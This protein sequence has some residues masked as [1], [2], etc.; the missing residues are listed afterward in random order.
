MT[1]KFPTR[2]LASIEVPDTPLITKAIA[3]ARENSDDF[4]FN[5]VMRSWLFGERVAAAN[6]ALKDRDQEVHAISAI[7]QDLGW[8][9]NQQLISKDKRFEVDGANAAR[10]FLIQ[11]GEKSKWD[12]HRLQLVWDTIALHAIPSIWMYKEIEAQAA[13]TGI[14]V[15]FQGPEKSP[16]GVL[17]RIEWDSVNK[18]FPLLNFREA[19]KNI[20]CGFCLTKPDT[21]YDSFPREFGE[22]F[23]PGYKP[24]TFIETVWQ[25]AEDN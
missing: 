5:H 4:T 3:Y 17:T 12:K 20:S 7:L 19:V 6:P 23:V 21:T 8:S 14:F 10:A 11:E 22:A 24:R 25:G 18:E 1:S 9:F 16:G 2:L 13:S 15:D